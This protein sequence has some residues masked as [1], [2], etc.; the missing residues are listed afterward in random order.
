VGSRDR[1]DYR[2]ARRVAVGLAF[3]KQVREHVRDALEVSDAAPRLVKPRGRD[4]PDAAA[5]RSVFEFEQRGDLL[6]AEPEGLGALDEA[7]AVHVADSVAAI[8]AQ[9]PAWLRHQAAAL[10]IAHG[11]DSNSR[12]LGDI[13]DSEA[14]WIDHKHPL[15]TVPKYGLYT[16]ATMNSIA[17]RA[18]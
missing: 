6:E 17:G 11:F 3:V 18:R 10:V 2:A 1:T 16:G 15:D 9:S 4:A 7:D 8:G 12:G 14:R 13:A 5:V